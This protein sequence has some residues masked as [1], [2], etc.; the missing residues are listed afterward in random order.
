MYRSRSH[1][2]IKD[3]SKTELLK[4][5]EGGMSNVAIAKSIGCSKST[6]YNLIGAQP[7]EITSRHASEAYYRAR[8]IAPENAEGARTVERKMMSFKPQREEPA[9]AVLVMK[10]LPPAPIPL[11]GA[12]MDYTISADRQTIE[13]ENETGRVLICVPAEKLGTFIEELQ[14]IEKNIAAEKPM[15][16]WG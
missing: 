13:E 10:T 16:F 9:K 3:I 12:F 6:I 5:R 7:K 1:G 14:A 2:L 11:H 15:P 8:N 4:M